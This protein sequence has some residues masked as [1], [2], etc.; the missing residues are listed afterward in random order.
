MHNEE[1]GIGNKRA[2]FLLIRVEFSW[3]WCLIDGRICTLYVKH[4]QQLIIDYNYWLIF[5]IV[6]NFSFH[7]P[8]SEELYAERKANINPTLS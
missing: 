5:D 6:G 1:I 4:T 3:L 7:F 2:Q 8:K